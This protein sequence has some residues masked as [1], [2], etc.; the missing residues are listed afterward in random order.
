[1]C[2][3]VLTLNGKLGKVHFNTTSVKGIAYTHSSVYCLQEIKIYSSGIGH[4]GI[5]K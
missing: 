5:E 4:E 1:M 3:K 2:F